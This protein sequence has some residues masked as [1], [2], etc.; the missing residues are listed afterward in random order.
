MGK[1]ESFA[2]IKGAFP[3]KTESILPRKYKFYETPTWNGK[4]F[5]FNRKYVKAV[6]SESIGMSKVNVQLLKKEINQAPE[7][8]YLHTFKRPL[9]QTNAKLNS[10]QKRTDSLPFSA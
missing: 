2:G 10:I 9:N 1:N 5:K 4:L 3:Q 7:M 8:L 6:S